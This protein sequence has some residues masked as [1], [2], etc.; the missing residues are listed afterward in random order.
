[1]QVKLI[2]NTQ[3][4]SDLKDMDLVCI[5]KYPFIFQ[6]KDDDCTIDRKS[7]NCYFSEFDACMLNGMICKFNTIT[8]T[9]KFVFQKIGDFPFADDRD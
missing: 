4:M 1:M 9:K 8:P 6:I 5:A 3:D 2:Y 7:S